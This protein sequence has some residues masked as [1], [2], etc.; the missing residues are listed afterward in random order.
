MIH[1]TYLNN[2]L[3]KNTANNIMIQIQRDFLGYLGGYVFNF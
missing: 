3:I 1:K 2:I